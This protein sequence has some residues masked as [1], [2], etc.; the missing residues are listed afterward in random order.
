M[1]VRHK[2]TG[3]TLEVVTVQR[4]ESGVLKVELDEDDNDYDRLNDNWEIV[5][6]PKPSIEEQLLK[7]TPGSVFHVVGTGS[8]KSVVMMVQGSGSGARTSNGSFFKH[9]YW[10]ATNMYKG[11]DV[12]VDFAA[13]KEY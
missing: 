9:D 11:G 8:I 12:V 7:L 13:P 2:S 1:Q 3:Q 4:L 6:P 5:P 10:D